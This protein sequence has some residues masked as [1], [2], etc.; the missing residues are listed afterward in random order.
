MT[1][2]FTMDRDELI[3]VIDKATE[4]LTPS[5]REKLLHVAQT[6]DAVAVGWFHC[7][8]VGCPSRQAS[9]S[10][11]KFQTAYDYAMTSRF[12]IDP[13]EAQIEPFIVEVA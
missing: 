11:Q 2:R 7:D 6:T 1:E 3:A 13:E 9:R 4:G 12:G 10:N 5:T 8:G